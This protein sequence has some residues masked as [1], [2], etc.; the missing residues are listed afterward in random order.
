MD[1]VPALRPCLAGIAAAGALAVLGCGGP[2]DVSG[3]HPH[4]V[5]RQT[6]FQPAPDFV[7]TPQRLATVRSALSVED[8]ILVFEGDSRLVSAEG[9]GEFGLT[10]DNQRALLEDAFAMVPDRFDTLVI[11]TAFD[12]QASASPR[13]YQPVRN[14][15]TGIGLQLFDDR[16]GYG[17]PEG[18]RL[19]GYVGMGSPLA[20]GDGSLAGLDAAQGPYHAAIAQQLASRWAFYLRFD[21]PTGEAS[22]ALLNPNVVGAWSQLAQ[23]DGSLLGGNAY[24]R[25]G[26]PPGEDGFA[27]YE[28]TGRNQGF[29]PLDLYAM[30]RV[31]PE[32]VPVFFY[33][34]EASVDGADVAPG[35]DIP[36][37]SVVRGK[38]NLVSMQQVIDAMGPR[39]PSF[40]TEDPYYRVAFAFVTTPGAPRSAWEDQLN[41]IKQV[42]TDLPA[43]WRAWGAGNLCTQITQ[44][45]PEP[46]LAL[47]GWS[48]V[49]DEDGLVGPGDT[50]RVALTVENSG[51]GTTEGATV[52]LESPSPSARVEGGP[53]TVPSIEQGGASTL[54]ETFEVTV[55]S[56]VA[57]GTAVSLRAILATREGPEFEGEVSI[58]IGTDRVR[59]DAMEEDVDWMVNPDGTDSAMG[60]R[61]ALGEPESAE[62]AGI[63]TQ[64]NEDHTPGEGKLSFHTGPELMGFFA[65]NSLGEGISTLQSPVFAIGQTEDPLLVFW[66]WRTAW[67]F[68]MDPP[69]PQTQ[70]PLVVQA[71]NDG[72]ASWV[73]LG[74]FE[75]QTEAWT[76]VSFRIRDAIEPTDRVRF[77]FLAEKTETP[78]NVELGIDDLEIVDFLASCEGS[79]PDPDPDPDPEPDPDANGD[80]DEGGCRCASGPSPDPAGLG[81]A[82]GLLVGVGTLRRR[83]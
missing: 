43:A 81:L 72:G 30:G 68:A 14:R 60:G 42:R 47:G 17:L 32:A 4:D 44:P 19:S 38:P 10:E 29:A 66:A 5:H 16:P 33:L 45:C 76:R 22:E 6:G 21:L 77:R 55:S 39:T 52:R 63:L 49:G 75:Q 41:L 78:G 57:C 62:V 70:A 51:I 1:L 58:P 61:W 67:N 13:Y 74:R 2:G 37:G 26:D 31:A 24:E 15:V 36:V 54:T 65:T 83:R 56:T 79:D 53:F 20:F 50:V 69:V 46:Q 12:D 3:S 35:T 64:P 11:F 9:P 34:S 80:D 7:P 8:D 18:G 40:D 48:L 71:S 23:S 25:V 27:M 73:E 59:I 28:N 82:L